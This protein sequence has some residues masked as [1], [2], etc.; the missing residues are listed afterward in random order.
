M[1]GKDPKPTGSEEDDKRDFQSHPV[2]AQAEADRIVDTIPVEDWSATQVLMAQT[3]PGYFQSGHPANNKIRPKV[4]QWYKNTF[5]GTMDLSSGQT[6]R[7]IE[8]LRLSGEV[9]G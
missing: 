3:S 4:D 8:G 9:E 2:T 1:N 6:A 7:K 5:Q